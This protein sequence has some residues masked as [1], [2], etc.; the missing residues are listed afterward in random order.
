MILIF[1]GFN[2]RYKYVNNILLDKYPG[3]SIVIQK[4][5]KGDHKGKYDHNPKYDSETRKL[6]ESHI[7]ERDITE[8]K[9]YPEDE[10]H[11]NKKTKHLYTT[12]S[13]LNSE[14]TVKF[15][16]NLTPKA[17]FVFGVGL[18]NNRLLQCFEKLEVINLHFG[19]T[20][21]YRGSNTLLWPLYLNDPAHLGITLHQ[22]D[23]KIDHG[24]IYHQQSTKFTKNDSIHEIFCKTI[25]QAVNPT[26]DLLDRIINKTIPPPVK[27]TTTGKIYNND[28]FTPIHLKTI[29]KSIKNGLL[30]KY[31]EE[32][33]DFDKPKLISVL[34]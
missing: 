15:V 3:S 8:S 27:N 31:L 11:F 18:L 16:D 33:S 25:I 4:D 29:Y 10:F 19:I 14:K 17:V 28:E 30:I 13:E 34:K 9:F 12:S 26:L 21:K 2:K 7:Q 20:P 22:I 32:K 24:P 5:F 1:S 23:S 6:F